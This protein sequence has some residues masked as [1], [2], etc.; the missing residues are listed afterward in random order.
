MEIEKIEDTLNRDDKVETE[1]HLET[2]H[3]KVQK[4]KS[5]SSFVIWKEIN[6]N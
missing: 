4:T 1:Q 5:E 3:S 6:Y 2:R